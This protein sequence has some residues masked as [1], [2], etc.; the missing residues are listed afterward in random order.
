MR[1]FKTLSNFFKS[2]K[3]ALKIFLCVLTVIMVATL[4]ICG[5]KAALQKAYNYGYERGR[6]NPRYMAR[7]TGSTFSFIPLD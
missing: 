7:D 4:S 6:D 5:L 1:L 2:H 3:A